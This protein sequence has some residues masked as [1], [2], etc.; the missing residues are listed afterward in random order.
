MAVGYWFVQEY[1]YGGEAGLEKRCANCD[2]AIAMAQAFKAKSTDPKM[3]MRVHVPSHATDD[4]RRQI[5]ELGVD[6]G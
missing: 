1:R 3:R 2:G 4:E 6:I 5:A